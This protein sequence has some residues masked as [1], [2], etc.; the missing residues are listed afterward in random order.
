MI[1]DTVERMVNQVFMH[2]PDVMVVITENKNPIGVVYK[3]DW[4]S[5]KMAHL[6]AK[7]SQAKAPDTFER[8]DIPVVGTVIKIEIA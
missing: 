8:G 2:E 1:I 4:E 7:C 5:E 3:E 6:R